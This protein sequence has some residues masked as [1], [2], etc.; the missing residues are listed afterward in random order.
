MSL[1]NARTGLQSKKHHTKCISSKKQYFHTGIDSALSILSIIQL[2]G[3]SLA[4]ETDASNRNLL[5]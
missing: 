3:T 5:L 1:A 2:F 4:S